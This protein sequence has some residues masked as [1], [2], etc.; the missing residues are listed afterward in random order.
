MFERI[1]PLTLWLEGLVQETYYANDLTDFLDGSVELYCNFIQ[2]LD[3][4]KSYRLWNVLGSTF[5][6]HDIVQKKY[7]YHFEKA[8]NGLSAESHVMKMFR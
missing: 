3:P 8:R 4:E 5:L 1:D 2:E 7:R 6:N